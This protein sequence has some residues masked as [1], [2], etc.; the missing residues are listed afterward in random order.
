MKTALLASERLETS[1]AEIL[2]VTLECDDVATCGLADDLEKFL[3]NG[4]RAET[5]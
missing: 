4:L 2:K 3:G 1:F 5:G